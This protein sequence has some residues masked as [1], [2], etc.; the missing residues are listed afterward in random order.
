LEEIKD[1]DP[2][3][4]VYSDESGIDDNEVPGKGWAPRGERCHDKKRGTRKTR[5]NITAALNVNTLFAPFIFEG[6]SN[7]AIYE[8]YIERVLIPELRPGMVLIIDN[9]RFHKGKRI[10]ELIEDAGC[11]LI[12]LPPYSPDFNPIEHCWHP[13]KNN[14]RKKAQGTN[15]FYQIAVN[16]LGEMSMA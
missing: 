6:Y 15:D 5:Y 3:L 9:A 16:V 13:V 2:S 14:I 7:S 11:R 1:I 10:Q 8:T 12:F 4:I